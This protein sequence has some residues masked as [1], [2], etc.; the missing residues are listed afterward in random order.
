MAVGFVLL[1]QRLEIFVYTRFVPT[2]VFLG[3]P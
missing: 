2:L 1:P 3:L